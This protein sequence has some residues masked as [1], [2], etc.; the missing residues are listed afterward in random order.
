MAVLRKKSNS[1]ILLND[2]KIADRF[3]LR[4]KGLLGT[5]SLDKNQGL[6][7]HDCN[8]IHTFF[9]KYAIDCIFLDRKM[10]ITK[11]IANIH[12]GRLLLPDWKS[13]SVIEISAGQTLTMN[14]QTGDELDVGH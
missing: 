3:L 13:Q 14:L 2:L 12:P 7:I 4:L 11:I 1:D 6:W 9:M 10:R 8:S 5:N